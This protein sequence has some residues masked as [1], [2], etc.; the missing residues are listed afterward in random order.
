MK[1]IRQGQTRWKVVV[2]EP[3]KIDGYDDQYVA[4]IYRCFVTAVSG[5]RLSYSCGSG[6]YICGSNWFIRNTESSYRRAYRKAKLMLN[7]V[8]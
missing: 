4:M 2:Y 1:K 7:N 5:S 6:P 8:E 3:G